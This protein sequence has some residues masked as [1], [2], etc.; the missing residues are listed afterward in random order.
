MRGNVGKLPEKREKMREN[1]GH[2]IEKCEIFGTG[3]KKS[4]K[5][6]KIG[7][8]ARKWWELGITKNVRIDWKWGES[9]EKLD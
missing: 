8:H 3:Q 2:A 5:Y 7:K 6:R 1:V 4:G 9:V